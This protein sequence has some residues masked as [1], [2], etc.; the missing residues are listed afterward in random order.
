MSLWTIFFIYIT[1]PVSHCMKKYQIFNSVD[2]AK[3]IF[4]FCAGQNLC[5]IFPI[6]QLLRNILR[7]ELQEACLCLVFLK[8][9]M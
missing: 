3:C 2:Y 8:V 1:S 4:P 6:F 7:H 5:D 9:L